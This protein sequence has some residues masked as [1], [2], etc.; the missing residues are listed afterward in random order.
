MLADCTSVYL[1]GTETSGSESVAVFVRLAGTSIV[2]ANF[3]V[4]VWYP[5]IPLTLWLNDNTLNRING[6]LTGS[7]CQSPS[8]QVA[9]FKVY[10]KFRSSANSP[11]FNADVTQYVEVGIR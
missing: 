7:N 1:N 8:Y 9:R 10:A 2:V 11:W 6:W 4:R 3:T 5:D